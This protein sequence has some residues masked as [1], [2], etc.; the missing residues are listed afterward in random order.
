MNTL[1]MNSHNGKCH[2]NT[3]QTDVVESEQT[4]NEYLGYSGQVTPLI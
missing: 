4:W 1:R 2:E 3:K